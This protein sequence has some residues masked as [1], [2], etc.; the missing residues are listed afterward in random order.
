MLFVDDEPPVLQALQ[1]SLWK[2]PFRVLTA[3]GADAALEV[4]AGT[5][6]DVI[7]SDER[8]PGVSG[9]ELL[10][11]VQTAFPRIVRIMLTGGTG[12]SAA[13]R[14]I[15]GASLYRLLSKPVSTEELARTLTQAL[16][17]Q[18]LEEQRALLHR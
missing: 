2:Q 1:R 15:N 4:L 9:S 11:R 16:H 6:V 17:L 12:L 7:V 14:A 13:V 10:Q 18:Q 3:D 8:M 5:P